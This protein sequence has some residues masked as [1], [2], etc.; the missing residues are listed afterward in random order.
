MI[1]E[2]VVSV[3]GAS[4]KFDAPGIQKAIVEAGFTPRRRNQ[5][6]EFIS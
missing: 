2:N 6:F 1:E 4:H 3:A 5:E